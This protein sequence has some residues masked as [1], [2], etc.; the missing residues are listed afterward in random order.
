MPIDGAENG[1]K[2][3]Q[4]MITRAAALSPSDNFR[5]SWSVNLLLFGGAGAKFSV[6]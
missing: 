5:S 6:A 1:V 3:Q 2:L 4:S